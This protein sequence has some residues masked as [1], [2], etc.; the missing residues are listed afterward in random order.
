MPPGPLY[1]LLI[2]RRSRMGPPWNVLRL[3]VPRGNRVLP[4]TGDTGIEVFAE[5]GA[6]LK[7]ANTK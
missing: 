4:D 7:T 1:V 3:A 6:V 5:E 2:C